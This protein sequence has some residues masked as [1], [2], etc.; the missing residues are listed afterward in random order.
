[1]EPPQK[2]TRWDYIRSGIY[3]GLYV[4][5]LGIGAVLLLPDY[6]YGWAVIVLGGLVGLVSWHQRSTIYLCPQCG[7]VYRISFLQ[8]LFSPHG[9][10]KQGAWLLLRCPHCSRRGKTRVLKPGSR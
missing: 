8:D 2:P 5:A 1:M 3:L 6:W 10:D 9:I 4:L 7:Q